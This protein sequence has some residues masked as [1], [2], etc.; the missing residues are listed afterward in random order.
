MNFFDD[1]GNEIYPDK[2]LSRGI[3]FA[4]CQLP[5]TEG[6]ETVGVF[7]EDDDNW[8]LQMTFHPRWLDDLSWAS[9]HAIPKKKKN[10]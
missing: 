2:V 10:I 7:V 6:L 1:D 8:F 4:I 9:K 3:I 5:D